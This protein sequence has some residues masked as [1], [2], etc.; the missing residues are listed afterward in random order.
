VTPEGTR[1]V[2]DRDELTGL[3]S[4]RGE[5]E[6]IIDQLVRARLIHMHTDVDQGA[7]I[8]IVH[9]TLITEWPT[10]GRWLDNS[11]ALRGF[12]HEVQQAARTWAA[13]GMPNHLV[14]RGAMARDALG[15]VSR[16]VLVLSEL[17][18]SFLAA[19]R[20]QTSRTRRR[21]LLVIASIFC[22]LGLVIAGGTVAFI[23]VS[24]ANAE[25]QQKALDADEARQ[26]AQAAE[27]K[28]QKQLDDV[29]AAQAARDR[30]EHEQRASEVK[31]QQAEGKAQVFEGEAKLSRSEL[32]LRNGQLNRA[33][34]EAQAANAKAVTANEVANKANATLERTLMRERERIRQLERETSKIFAGKLK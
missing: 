33:L 21:K 18:R 12:L 8:E 32:E 28:L 20:L 1:A 23:Q 5:G 2:V 22:T 19:V 10:L 15:H 31:A 9:E 6:R 29:N 14:W 13:R 16:D 7:T 27:V 25:A 30:A 26:H 34:A 4:D 17:E 24:R 11:S 3:A